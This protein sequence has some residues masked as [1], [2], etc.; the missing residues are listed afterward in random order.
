[1]NSDKP[2]SAITAAA[3][4]A[5]RRVRAA[6]VE[7][8]SEELH[9]RLVAIS[10]S[11]AARTAAA[12]AM[13]SPMYRD[14]LTGEPIFPD[15]NKAPSA[16]QPLGTAPKPQVNTPQIVNQE[17]P[18]SPEDALLERAI[19]DMNRQNPE[20]TAERLIKY[21]AK[22]QPRDA[23]GRFRQ[24]LARIK[25]DLGTSG[26]ARALKKIEE[27]ENLDFAGNYKAAVSAANELL[28]IIDRLDTGALNKESL[29]NVRA[30]SAELGKVIA[31]LPFA[32]GDQNAKIRYSDVP[33]ALK[34]LIDSMMERVEKKIGKKDAA[35]ANE[36]LRKFKSGGFMLSQQDISSQMATLLRLL[37]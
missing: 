9:A 30:S 14:I 3:E 25:Q 29:E 24:V 35:K 13:P 34:E 12:S 17:M 20:K 36:T 16:E 2:K 32:F 6:Q 7:R 33:A 5:R 28:G 27:A 19:V 11:L 21:T 8:K 22:T 26:N 31:N 18:K 1:M 23:S 4:A 10:A 15:P 37:T